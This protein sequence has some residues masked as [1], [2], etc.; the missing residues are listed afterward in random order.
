VA[1]DPDW[2][3]VAALQGGED[4][5]LNRIMDR[6][7]E[8]VYGFIRHMIGHAADAEELTQET[9]VRAYFAVDRF[10]PRTLFAAWLFQIARNLCR[11]YFRSRA[12]R[13][14]QQAS[15]WL[16]ELAEHAVVESPNGS[17]DGNEALYAA[18]ARLPIALRECIVLTAIEGLSHK[19]AARQLGISAKAVEIKSYRARKKLASYLKKSEG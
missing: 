17:G 3:D 16:E 14:R 19:E 10:R 7:R 15:P 11:D 1:D 18:L 4:L 13:Q 8:P 6:Y 12:Y 5:A 2:P 9:F